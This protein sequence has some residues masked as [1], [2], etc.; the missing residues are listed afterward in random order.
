MTDAQVKPLAGVTVI[1]LAR[2]LACPFADMI[3][4][5][6]GATVIKIEQPGTGDETRSFEPQVGDESAYYFACN[7][8]KQSVTA[9]LK[10]EAGR[11]IVRELAQNADILIEN[12]PVGTLARYG[13]DHQTLRADNERL[14]YVSCTG[15]G[16]TGP[17]A[18]RK[19][20]DT[21][22]QAMGGIMSLTGE[23]GGGPVKPGLPIADLTSGMWIA[24]GLLSALNGRAMTGKGCHI[25]FS[26]L[27]GQV[28]LLTLA[29]GRFFAL[30]EVPPRLGTEHPGRVPSATFACSDG[31]FVHITCSDQHWL[32]LCKLLKLDALAGDP[33][34]STNAGRVEHRERVMAALTQAIAGW[35][36]QALCDACDAEGVPAG[37]IKDVAEV[38]SDP[39]V[40][41]RGMVSEFE[42]P[43]IGTFGALPLPFKFDGFAD[44]EVVRPPLLGEHTEQV[45]RE[46]LGY[47]AQHIAALR[48][49]GAI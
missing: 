26:M 32:P 18:K 25:D 39:H 16:Q 28:S 36:R 41:A 46:R 42:H 35:T 12:F 23:R 29:A 37:P 20:Y 6:L 40:K 10:T 17:Y 48:R 1:E 4:A 45:L 2:V 15:F 49:D 38:L 11:R 13:L 30:G 5:E 3:L 24:I 22:F 33:L 9:N 34:L 7:R 31:A 8:G 14:V 47:D 19:G 27:D 44:P 21:V 43:T